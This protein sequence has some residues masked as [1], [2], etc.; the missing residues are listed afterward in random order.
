MSQ[1]MPLLMDTQLSIT[2]SHTQSIMPLLIMPPQLTMPPQLIT[3]QLQYT[4]QLQLLIMPQSYTNQLLIMPQLYTN[5][6]PMHASPSPPHPSLTLPHTRP[7]V[8]PP[9]RPPTR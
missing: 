6:L 3:S 1:Y 7:P 5:Q 4:T 8:R 9:A 2:P